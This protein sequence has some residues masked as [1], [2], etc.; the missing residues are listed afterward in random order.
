MITSEYSKTSEYLEC[1]VDL[2]KPILLVGPGESQKFR[3]SN[4]GGTKL[5]FPMD[6]AMIWFAEKLHGRKGR[7]DVFDLPR[8]YISGGLH[9]PLACER[10]IRELEKVAPIGDVKFLELGDI[11]HANLQKGEYGFIWDHDTLYN[12][13]AEDPVTNTTHYSENESRVQTAL[14]N[15]FQSLAKGGKIAIATPF[16]MKGRISSSDLECEV[17]TIQ[18][19]QDVYSTNLTA[20]QLFLGKGGRFT[21]KLF[22]EGTL[23]PEYP[24]TFIDQIGKK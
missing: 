16:G 4:E 17:E 21:D 7:L 9:D 10:Y 11:V 2:N 13:V 15:Y 5:V 3:A 18:M 12:W 19:I 24:C 20:E 6:A 8:K 22:L 14:N 1:V 23:R